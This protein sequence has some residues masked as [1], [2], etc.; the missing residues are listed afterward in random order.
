[1]FTYSLILRSDSY[2]DFDIIQ[3]VKL[4]VHPAKKIDDHPQWNF[5]DDEAAKNGDDDEMDDEFTTESE[6]DD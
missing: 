4:D 3:N 5:T 1:M 2:L 6:N